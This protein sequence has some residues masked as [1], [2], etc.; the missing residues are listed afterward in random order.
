MTE[1]NKEPDKYSLVD[2]LIEEISSK[3]RRYQGRMIKYRRYANSMD[4]VITGAGAISVSSLVF[5]A[6]SFNPISLAIGTAF[7]AVSTVSNAI[8]KS[9]NYE[10][11]YESCKTTFNQL[12][13]LERDVKA[14]LVKN[15]L[16]SKDIQDLLYNIGL[17]LSLIEDSSLP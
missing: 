17:R 11:K 16:S 3:K 4:V 7:S 5:T 15:S 14:T 2:E 13:D 9:V 12:S 6:T 1:Y 8:S 10:G